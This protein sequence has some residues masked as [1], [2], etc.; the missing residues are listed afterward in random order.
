MLFS[1]VATSIYILTNQ[2]LRVF[3][4]S[5]PWQHLLFVVF[6]MIAN[7]TGSGVIAHCGFNVHFP[8]D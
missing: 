6:F 8:D 5:H 2:C 7:L 1:T 3:F 4:S